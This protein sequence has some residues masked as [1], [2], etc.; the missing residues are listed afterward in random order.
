MELQMTIPIHEYAALAALRLF[1]GLLQ[2]SPLQIAST[3]TSSN[4]RTLANTSKP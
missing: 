1:S 3:Y 2:H 4:G